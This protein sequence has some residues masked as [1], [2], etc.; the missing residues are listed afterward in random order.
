MYS[1]RVR[2]ARAWLQLALAL[3][4]L[5]VALG[6]TLPAFARMAAGPKAH[7]CHCQNAGAHTH[8]ECPVC[9]PELGASLETRIIAVSG[10]CGDDDTG[11][12]TLSEPAVVPALVITL[13]PLVWI[14]DSDA[15]VALL[16]SRRIEPPEPPPPR[17]FVS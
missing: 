16:E 3:L 8:C 15:R 2:S 5:I 9:F 11:W 14:V 4:S 6:G 1:I 12:R 13:A 17:S 10:K 7:V